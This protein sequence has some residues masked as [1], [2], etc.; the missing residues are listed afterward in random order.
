MLTMLTQDFVSHNDH[1]CQ[2]NYVVPT[3]KKN[4]IPIAHERNIMWTACLIA[5]NLLITAIKTKS[6]G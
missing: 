3:N 4:D 5:F 1:M 6:T 2:V